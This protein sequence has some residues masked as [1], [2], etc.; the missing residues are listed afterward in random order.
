MK[1]TVIHG[2]MRKGNTYN[3]TQAVLELLRK[4]EGVQITEISVAD[5]DLPFC[6]SCHACFDKGDA[7]CPH[8]KIIAPVVHEIENCDGLIISGV[9][10][11]MQI[12][13]SIKNLIDHLAYLFHRPRLFNKIG[14]V[15]TTTAGAGENRVAKYLR[16]VLGHWGVGKAILLPMK[17]QT[18]KFVL[19]D[20]QKKRIRA[21]AD[22]FY[23][24]IKTG[25]LSPPSLVSIIVHNG[26]R[27]H[28]SLTPSL[29][30][31]DSAYWRESNF[32][33]KVYPRKIGVGKWLIGKMM[34][35]IM[36]KVFKKVGEKNM[37]IKSK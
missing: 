26:F 36:R 23:N 31:A 33:K 18:E 10:Y 2:S 17:I 15:V 27:A 37:E 11:A 13:A 35:P 34:Y 29:S 24:N 9:C 12:N 4:H 8:H 22:R 21:A 20:K 19:S 7:F 14:M 5:L 16:Q 6:V 1:I 3:V 25:K 32:A 30:E 28:A